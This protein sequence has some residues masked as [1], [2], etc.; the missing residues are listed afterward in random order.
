VLIPYLGIRG[1]T[2]LAAAINFLVAI[3]AILLQDASVLFPTTPPRKSKRETKTEKA[4]IALVLSLA[5]G[6]AP[7]SEVSWSQAIIPFLSTRAFAFSISPSGRLMVQIIGAMAEFER[8]LIQERVR[9]GLRN[10]RAKGKRLGRPRHAYPQ[11]TVE[12][13]RDQGLLRKA[14]QETR[15]QSWQS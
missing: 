2:I 10:A 1:S 7:G 13:L 14:W 8:A 6:V 3:A 12:R 15:K 11:A 5:G 4:W 9:A